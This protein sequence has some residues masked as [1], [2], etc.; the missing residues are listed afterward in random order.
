M[1]IITLAARLGYGR[2]R[3][4]FLALLPVLRDYMFQQGVELP[5]KSREHTLQRL[6]ELCPPITDDNDKMVA[7]VGCI[8]TEKKPFQAFWDHAEATTRLHDL[9]LSDAGMA[10]LKKP[11]DKVRAVMFIMGSALRAHTTGTRVYKAAEVAYTRPV[12][13]NRLGKYWEEVEIS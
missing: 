6:T 2:T 8:D 1:Q 4:D 10:R 13:R 11:G 9:F 12:A 5:Q 3:S 7:V